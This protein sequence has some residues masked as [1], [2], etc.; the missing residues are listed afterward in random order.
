M[1]DPYGITT[2]NGSTIA[3]NNP[4]RY[5]SG[6]QDPTGLYHLNARY[7]DTSLGR[8]TQLDPSGQDPFSYAY[9]NND[10][11]NGADPSGTG[12]FSTIAKTV[13]GAV[14]TVLAVGVFCTATAGVGCAIAAGV[15]GGA[16]FGAAGGIL[17][18]PKGQETREGVDG[19]VSG[20][21]GGAI[22]GAAGGRAIVRGFS[23]LRGR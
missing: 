10:P 18:A 1:Y 7:Y 19:A 8:F 16:I 20:A 17:A 11:I 13:G 5:T 21:I 23:N 4:W 2:T 22:G 6:Y 3:T 15:A 12:L 14:G 9:A